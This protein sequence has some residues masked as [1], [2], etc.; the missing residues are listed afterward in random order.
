MTDRARLESRPNWLATLRATRTNK[1]TAVM[2]TM[3]GGVY[4]YHIDYRG[5]FPAGATMLYDRKRLNKD[6]KRGDFVI[7]AGSLEVGA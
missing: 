1:F 5:M 4:L 2:E 3:Q 6:V 7:V